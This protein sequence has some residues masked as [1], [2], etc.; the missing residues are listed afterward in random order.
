MLT[1][2]GQKGHLI[3]ASRRRSG[4]HAGSQGAGPHGTMGAVSRSGGN[5]S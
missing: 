2:T 3:L 4:C 1:R 5:H